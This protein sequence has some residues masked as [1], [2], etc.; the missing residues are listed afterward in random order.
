M[1][2]VND[3]RSYFFQRLRWDVGCASGFS[4]FQTTEGFV[5]F[6]FGDLS[7]FYVKWIAQIQL[8][9]ALTQV[10]LALLENVL[11][12]SLVSLPPL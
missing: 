3:A 1:Q 6:F 7:N 2:V 5:N 11:S 8:R 10:D 4:V 9:S 12:T